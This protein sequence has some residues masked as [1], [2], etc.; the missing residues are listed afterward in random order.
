MRKLAS[1]VGVAVAAW[2]AHALA[3]DVLHVGQSQLDPPTLLALGVQ[4]QITGDDNFNAS[5]SVRYR[6]AGA[7]SWRDAMPLMRVHPEDVTGLTVPPQFAGSIFGLRPAT[8]YEIE[9]HATDSDGNVD[10]VLSLS[11]TTRAVPADPKTPNVVQ[12]TDTA[13]LQSALGSA[14]A[15]DVITLAAGTYAGSFSID[16]SGTADNP[17]V[18]RGVDRDTVILDGQGCDPCNVLEVYGSF[19]HVEKLTIAHASR[20]LRFQGQGAE[21]NVVRR[22]KIQDVVLGIGSKD[23][24]KNFYICDNELQGRLS[25]PAVYKDDGGA[26]ANDDGINMAGNGHVVCHNR[27]TGF[28]DAMKIEQDGAVAVDFYG[29]EV[30]SAYDNGVEL[31]ASQRNARC[32]S[33]RFTNTYA[34]ISFQPIFGG[35]AY[36][37]RNVVVNVADEQMKFHALG[38]TPPEEPSGMIVLHN[39]FVSPSHALWMQTDATSHHF[40]IANNIFLGPAS[41][42]NGRTVDWTGGMEDGRWDYDGFFP[43]GVF[44]MHL[45]ATYEKFANFA[46]VQAGGWMPHGLLLDQATFAN[47]L[48]APATYTAALQPQDATLAAGSKAL[49]KG[50]VYANV[51]DGYQGSAPDLG[52]LE[53]GCAVPIYGVRPEGTDESN[54]VWGCTPGS[55]GAAGAGGSGAGG[56]TS[57]AGGASAGGAGTAGKG[58]TAGAGASGTGGNPGAS[59]GSSDDGGCGCRSAGR[60]VPSGWWIAMLAV[61]AAAVRLLRFNSGTA[62]EPRAGTSRSTARLPRTG[63]TTA[64]G[65]SC[66]ATS[67][68]RASSSESSSWQAMC[69][70]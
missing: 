7:G 43:D 50:A 47:G 18:I 8:A 26:H 63:T 51:N 49:D 27:L 6:E 58:G 24:Q 40:V 41:P 70:A 53:L 31:D 55:G 12:V 33:N 45:G 1:L 16:A 68:A 11:G 9:L 29:N 54:Q 5:V 64:A 61:A 36:A 42:E 37:I 4:L 44:A 39:T 35:P 30:L 2:S 38:T 60:E 14:K 23:D 62:S 17:I 22:V 59:P 28:G 52:A 32:F 66:R 15:G 13:S 20:G 48:A 67:H 34:T 56:G 65:E 21:A 69:G 10:Q 57:G 25:W 46:A 3:D 19:V